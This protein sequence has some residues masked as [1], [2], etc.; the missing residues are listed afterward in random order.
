[1]IKIQRHDLN[2]KF[3]IQRQYMKFE[4]RP[5]MHNVKEAVQ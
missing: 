1:M 3:E 2:Y 5:S 4:K